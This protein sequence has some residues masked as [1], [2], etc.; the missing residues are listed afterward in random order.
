MIMRV[1]SKEFSAGFWGKA[2]PA[3]IVDALDDWKIAERWTPASLSSM[4]LARRVTYSRSRDGRFR[5]DGSEAGSETREFE[6]DEID[7]REI[8]RRIE[9]GAE[10]RH[11]Y[12]MQQSI[13]DVLPELMQYLTVP[14]WIP[15][16]QASVN[17]WLGRA[18][19][20]QL[21]F[22]YTNN[23]FAQLHGTKRFTLFEPS[24]SHRLY[25]YHHANE[26]S[27]LSHVDVHAPDMS[28]F[29]EFANAK[30]WSFEIGP[31]ELLFLPAFWWHHVHA[32]DVSVSVSFWWKPQVRQVLQAPNAVRALS[33]FYKMDRL[34]EFK[35]LFLI[36][37]QLDFLPAAELFLDVGKTWA[38]CVLTLAAFDEWSRENV[39]LGRPPRPHGCQLR[40]LAEDLGQV[41]AELELDG[42]LAGKDDP[43]LRSVPVL[44]AQAAA[45][46]DDARIEQAPVRALHRWV[47]ALRGEGPI[48]MPAEREQGNPREG[49][50]KSMQESEG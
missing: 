38:A 27:H 6:T 20:S 3:I 39:G 17:L 8:V 11:A 40:D 42:R 29:P 47:H 1:T 15:S 22:D 23:F 35:K 33:N 43:V 34:G 5:Y 18:T 7:F 50:A 32:E 19:T 41:C 31:G 37:E 48:A 9:A 44:A 10:G 28:R 36:P 49:F 45:S 14:R 16:E 13:P 2:Q 26:T 21:H 46:L 30:A 12:V 25:P 24:D 4:E